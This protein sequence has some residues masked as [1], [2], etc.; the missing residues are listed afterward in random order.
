M[1]GNQRGPYD[2]VDVV[3][4]EILKLFRDRVLGRG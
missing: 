2:E 3:G 1:I 4:G